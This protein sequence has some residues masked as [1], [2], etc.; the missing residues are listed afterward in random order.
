MTC[1]GELT[2]KA[3]LSNLRHN[4]PTPPASPPKCH[5]EL[6]DIGCSECF[7]GVKTGFILQ[8][9]DCRMRDLIKLLVREQALNAL[10]YAFICSERTDKLG[11]F[12]FCCDKLQMVCGYG[13]EYSMI[14]EIKVRIRAHK[15]YRP[16]ADLCPCSQISQIVDV[17]MIRVLY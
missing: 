13:D 15:S 7:V 8:C 12:L 4:L 2:P 14:E 11:D 17:S 9:Q 6:F 10:L 3:S 16:E 1:D 5:S